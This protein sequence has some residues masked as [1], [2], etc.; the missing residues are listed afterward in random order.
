MAD[1]ILIVDD[2]VEIADLIEVYLR[3]ENY[4][5]FKFYTAK[6]AL[7]CINTTELDLAILDIFSRQLII[8]ARWNSIDLSLNNM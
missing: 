1:K 8:S 5:V 4:A 3:N 7:E 6:D 2:E